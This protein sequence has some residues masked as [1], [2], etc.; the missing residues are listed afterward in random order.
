MKAE[1][2]EKEV[3]REGGERESKVETGGGGRLIHREKK[4]RDQ[5]TSSFL[6]SDSF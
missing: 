5:T 2:D 3:Q 1:G 4:I 6:L